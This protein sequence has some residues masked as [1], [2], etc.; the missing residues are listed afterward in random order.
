MK[1]F[2]ELTPQWVLEKLSHTHYADGDGNISVYTN[3]AT[4]ANWIELALNTLDIT[5]DENDYVDGN[6]EIMFGFEFR[7]EDI[8]NDC[9]SFYLKMEDLDSNNFIHKQILKN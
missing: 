4:D 8:K 1:K 9:P 6:D 3:D 7:I 2:I 5:F